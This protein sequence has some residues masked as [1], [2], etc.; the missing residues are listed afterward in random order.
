MKFSHFKQ[1]KISMVD[2]SQ[3]KITKRE[4]C[5][6]SVIIFSKKSFKKLI[7]DGSPKGE[8]FNVARCAGILAAKKTSHLIPLCHNINLNS[9]EIN[10]DIDEK[11]LS[12]KVFSKVN[13]S[14]STGVEMEALTACSVASLTIYDMCKSIDKKITITDIKLIYKSGGKTGTFK[15]DK[16]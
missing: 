2:I 1:K 10:F 5:A 13:T 4:A 12:L 3:K 8:I 9:I 7:M 15:N 14:F 16:L 6:S 11:N